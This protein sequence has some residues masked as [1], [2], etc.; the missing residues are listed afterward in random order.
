MECGYSRMNVQGEEC[1]G[2]LCPAAKLLVDMECFQG[3]S[4]R[5][6]RDAPRLDLARPV[7]N[8]PAVGLTSYSRGHAAIQ[9]TSS[10]Q[11]EQD[12]IP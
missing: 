12:E 2:A 1:G 3:V 5:S 7:G 9:S 11:K 10:Q 8:I 6:F 4:S